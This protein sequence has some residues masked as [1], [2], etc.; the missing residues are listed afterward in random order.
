MNELINLINRPIDFGKKNSLLCLLVAMLQ[1]V[2][3]ERY[4]F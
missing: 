3:F 4:Q 1:V 2:V